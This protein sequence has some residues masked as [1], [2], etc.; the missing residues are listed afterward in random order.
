MFDRSL[1]Y[2]NVDNDDDYEYLDAT[3][4]SIGIVI[5]HGIL[6][7][8]F[9]VLTVSSISII[10]SVKEY[11]EWKGIW[12]LMP[13]LSLYMAIESLTIAI[14]SSHH[15]IEIPKGYA[16][17]LYVIE[18]IM[19]PGLVYTTFIITFIAYRIRSMPFCLVHRKV[20]IE[21]EDQQEGPSSTNNQNTT[22]LTTTT[23]ITGEPLVQPNILILFMSMFSLLLLTLSIVVNFDV[24]WTDNEDLAG[25]TGWI[26]VF[27]HPWDVGMLHVF[28]SLLPMLLSS[29]SCMYFAILFY[30]YG[31]GISLTIYS[32]ILNN[33]LWPIIGVLSM[34]VGQI[35]ENPMFA[36]TS[37]IGICIYQ[38]AL[39]MTLLEVRKDLGQATELGD[40]LG[41][42]CW[43]ERTTIINST[44]MTTT[45]IAT[46]KQM[47]LNDDD[48]DDVVAT[49]TL[50]EPKT[51]EL[52]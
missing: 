29:V 37:N 30:R 22:T 47:F 25:R 8:M 4:T 17:F 45:T 28:L 23:Q 12:L 50:Q 35:F 16:M 6:V 48:D 40:Y 2:L 42:L 27:K 20:I 36:L 5:G 21:E 9:T 31:N 51:V 46:N 52:L 7:S 43:H 11:Q 14:N 3:T 1:T 39:V 24:V 49:V 41:A 15:T 18:G 13:T 26:T 38:F 44:T 10:R 32:S 34:F 19:A 33:W